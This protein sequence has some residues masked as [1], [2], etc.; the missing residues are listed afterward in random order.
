MGGAALGLAACATATQAPTTHTC[1]ACVACGHTGHAATTWRS[2]RRGSHRRTASGGR[3]R[4]HVTHSPSPSCRSRASRGRSRRTFSSTARPAVKHTG[5]VRT[6]FVRVS[7]SAS[8][9]NA[10]FHRT[11]VRI[12]E[13]WNHKADPNYVPKKEEAR[14][15][16]RRLIQ[17]IREKW[18]AIQRKKARVT[19]RAL[20]RANEA[21]KQRAA[22]CPHPPEPSNGRV[23][24]TGADFPGV[25]D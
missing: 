19:E 16:S 23:A 11:A 7:C 18:L 20:P 9:N 22:C 4:A 5:R 15:P 13:P 3:T 14:T 17:V 6:S 2:P 8:F 21:R 25:P 12:Q 24:G 10:K 1:V